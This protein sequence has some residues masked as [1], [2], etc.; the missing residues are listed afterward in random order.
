[1]DGGFSAFAAIGI[2]S[3]LGLLCPTYRSPIQIQFE[4]FCGTVHKHRIFGEI[5]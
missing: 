3:K 4:C 5:D 2:Q 1:M